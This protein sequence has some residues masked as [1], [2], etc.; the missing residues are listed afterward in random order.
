MKSFFFGCFRKKKWN[1]LKKKILA[2]RNTISGGHGHLFRDT[3][4]TTIEGKHGVFI[5]FYKKIQKD[6]CLITKL[7]PAS[8]TRSSKKHIFEFKL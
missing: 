1:F 7:L 2:K 6:S 3:L 5:C 4:A 8:T